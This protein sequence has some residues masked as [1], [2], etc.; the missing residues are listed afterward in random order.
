[1]TDK[2]IALEIIAGCSNLFDIEHRIVPRAVAALT[3]VRKEARA[4]AF[5][6][7]RQQV[8]D[9]HADC[10]CGNL[11]PRDVDRLIEAAAN[12]KEGAGDG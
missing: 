6:S 5:K 12:S 7:L 3:A 10:D 1:M 2:D 9:L 8:G 4:A 11:D